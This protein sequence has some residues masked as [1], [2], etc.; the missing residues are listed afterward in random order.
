MIQ[1]GCKVVERRPPPPPPPPS[2]STPS[3]PRSTKSG[4]NSLLR[5]GKDG[6]AF[7]E[8]L[9]SH[10]SVLLPECLHVPPL[11]HSPSPPPP[12]PSFFSVLLRIRISE[13]ASQSRGEAPQA[14]LECFSSASPVSQR[15]RAEACCQRVGGSGA[16]QL[17]SRSQLPARRACVC[18]SGGEGASCR[19]R[20][21]VCVDVRTRAQKRWMDERVSARK[22]KLFL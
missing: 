8:S 22:R 1:A 19:A 16:A 21:S 7:D 11:F 18:V 2:P 15:S 20:C 10:T 12:R 5:K 3:S 14:S 17:V 9:S 6:E 4:E 13:G